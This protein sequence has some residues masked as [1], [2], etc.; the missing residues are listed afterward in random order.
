MFVKIRYWGNSFYVW[1]G[2]RF[3]DRGLGLY[4]VG[5]KN[6]S[7][8]QLLL[9]TSARNVKPQRSGKFL[10]HLPSPPRTKIVFVQEKELQ[11]DK[12]FNFVHVFCV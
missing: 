5:R 10:R 12:K 4:R 3:P 1:G 9:P 6:K 2:D 11:M 7:R 8:I